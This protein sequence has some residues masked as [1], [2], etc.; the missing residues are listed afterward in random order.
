MMFDCDRI[1]KYYLNY[2]HNVSTSKHK[3]LERTDSEGKNASKINI[4]DEI[5]NRLIRF[6][7]IF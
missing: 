2:Y 1:Y 4:L 6:N 7:D 3:N 5:Q